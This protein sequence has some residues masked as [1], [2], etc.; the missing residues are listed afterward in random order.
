MEATP[1]EVHVLMQRREGNRMAPAGGRGLG[2]R[3]EL[4]S[5]I[6]AV[7]LLSYE[8]LIIYDI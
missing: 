4:S 3:L 7:L 1:S 6:S 8:D 2:A 5:C